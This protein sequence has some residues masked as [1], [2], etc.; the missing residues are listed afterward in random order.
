MK[1]IFE[2]IADREIPAVFVYEDEKAMVIMDKFP[3]VAGQVLIV[4]KKAI[5]YVFDLD[6]ETYNYIFNLAKKIGPAMHKAMNA[7]RVCML[8]EGFHVP[9]V[10]IKM[11]PVT[12]GMPLEIHMGPEVADDIL[13]KQAEK[14][15]SA[16]KE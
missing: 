13:A 8:V 15:R 3:A 9:H 7:K 14:I 6:E 11:Y 4:P 5:D 12:E 10:H 1:T 16:L 2:K